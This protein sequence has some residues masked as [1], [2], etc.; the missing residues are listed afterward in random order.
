MRIR[1][2]ASHAKPLSQSLGGNLQETLEIIPWHAEIDII[3]PRDKAAMTP[4]T[5]HRTRIQK[6]SN[7]ILAT[8]AIDCL[9]NP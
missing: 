7:P 1:S 8:H 3:I 9:K 5:K 4:S 6:V 2:R